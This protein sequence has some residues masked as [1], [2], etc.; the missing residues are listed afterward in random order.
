MYKKK[1]EQFKKYILN[2]EWLKIKL[3]NL[4]IIFNKELLKIHFNINFLTNNGWKYI[5]ILIFRMNKIL[6]LHIY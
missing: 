6:M 4:N 5:L 3:Q 2:K 1:F